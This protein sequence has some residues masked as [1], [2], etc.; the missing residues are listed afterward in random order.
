MVPIFLT[1]CAC[2]SGASHGNDD[3]RTLLRLCRDGAS[4]SGTFDWVGSRSGTNTRALSGSTTDGG[5]T[6][7]DDAIVAQHPNPGWRFCTV[8]RYD[9]RWLP[10]GGLGGT[11]WS[12]AFAD[13]A[14]MELHPVACELPKKITEFRPS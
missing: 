2:F 7:H 10:D 6:L 8:D 14:T 9:L 13:R 3:V 5:V 11:F 4:V 12:A 1:D